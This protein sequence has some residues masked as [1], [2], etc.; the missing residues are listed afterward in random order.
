MS[1]YINKKMDEKL[2]GVIVLMMC[3]ICSSVSSAM[4]MGGGDGSDTSGSGGSGGS[5]GVDGRYVR[6]S[7]SNTAGAD[8]AYALNILE[9]EVYDASGTNIAK[10]KTATSSSVYQNQDQYQAVKAFDGLD[11]TLFHSAHDSVVDWLEV[12][13]GGIKKI[14]KI[15]IKHPDSDA[16]YKSVAVKDR[17][18]GYVEI[19]DDSS[20][21]VKTTPEITVTNTTNTY[22]YDFTK[23]SPTW[24]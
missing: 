7:L 13:L 24:E 17:L 11:D 22:T 4:S 23:A 18:R 12:D 19:K 5:G 2:I 1:G 15:V 6:V 21:V 9:L 8:I 10:N 16:S 20:V 3:C 14:N